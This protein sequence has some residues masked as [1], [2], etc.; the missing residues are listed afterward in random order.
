MTLKL[1]DLKTQF[2]LIIYWSGIWAGL[3]WVAHTAS[4]GAAE[5]ELKDPLPRWHIHM[6]SRLFSVVSWELSPTIIGGRPQFLSI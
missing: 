6:T 3:S 4:A 2:Y 5:M 1:D